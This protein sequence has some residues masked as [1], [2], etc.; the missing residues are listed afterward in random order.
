MRGLA[1]HLFT[2]KFNILIKTR[3]QMYDSN[4]QMT[5]K[6]LEIEFLR[7]RHNN[8]RHCYASITKL[9]GICKTLM[10]YLFLDI[11]YE[12]WHG[13]SNNVVCATSKA[14]DQPVHTDGLIRALAS[15]LNIL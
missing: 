10:F 15:C 6:L 4:Y 2:S 8:T 5:L 14:S 7:F 11:S 13:N 12:P 9:Y 3:A 1:E